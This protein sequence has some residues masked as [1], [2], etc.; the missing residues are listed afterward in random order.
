M[1]GFISRSR[2]VVAQRLNL[3]FTCKVCTLGVF[4][5]FL[6]VLEIFIPRSRC[7]LEARKLCSLRFKSAFVLAMVKD[8][9]ITLSQQLLQSILVLCNFVVQRSDCGWMLSL[10][11]RQRP[12]ALHEQLLKS[13]LVLRHHVV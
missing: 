7:I 8:R 10:E 6:H 13:A 2:Q 1:P 9:P 5:P 11:L 4:Q 12:F 3:L